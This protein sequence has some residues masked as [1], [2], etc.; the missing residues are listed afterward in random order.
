V[1]DLLEELMEM[2]QYVVPPREQALIT[3][4]QANEPSLH[5]DSIAYRAFFIRYSLADALV[6]H[7]FWS[8]RVVE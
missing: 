4:A 8:T 2:L 7:S 1:R 3:W 6:L 5:V